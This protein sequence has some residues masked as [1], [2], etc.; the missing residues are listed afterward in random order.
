MTGPMAALCLLL[1]LAVKLSRRVDDDI[2]AYRHRD[3]VSGSGC[4][5]LLWSDGFRH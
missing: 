1:A 4:N 5:T 3:C 2:T